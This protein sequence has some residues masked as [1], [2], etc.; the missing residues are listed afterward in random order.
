MASIKAFADN[1]I[2][3]DF[4]DYKNYGPNTRDDVV[5]VIRRYLYHFE[6]LGHGSPVRVS[7]NDVREFISKNNT[8]LTEKLLLM[9]L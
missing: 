3:K 7:V 9:N 5:W 2:S 6:A 4:P 8:T 1:G